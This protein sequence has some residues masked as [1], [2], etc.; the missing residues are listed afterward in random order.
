MMEEL[1]TVNSVPLAEILRGRLE[2]EGIEAALFDQGFAG[3]LGGGS[4]GIRVMVQAGR[5]AEARRLLG[6]P[7]NEA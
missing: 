6:L 1:V 4:P 5:A 7:E 3:L 2:A